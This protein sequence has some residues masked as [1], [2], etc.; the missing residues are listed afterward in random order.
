MASRALD[1]DLRRGAIE[2]W[3]ERRA[4]QAVPEGA[5]TACVHDCCVRTWGTCV[6]FTPYLP[7]Y[8]RLYIAGR[9]S[10]P[11]VT[12]SANCDGEYRFLGVPAPARP[13]SASG[14]GA[15]GEDCD[16]RAYVYTYINGYGEE[17]APSPPSGLLTVRDGDPVLVSGL[18]PP[19]D[20]WGVV[21][22]AVY[23]LAT[24]ARDVE[25]PDYSMLAGWLRVA[26]LAGFPP[27]YQDSVLTRRL[28]HALDTGR[29]RVPPPDL[30]CL[31]HLSGTGTLCGVTANA[32]HFSENFRP[33]SWPAELDNT[34]PFN[35]ANMVTLDATVLLTSDGRAYAVDA[36]NVCEER[37]L[38]PFRDTDAP[39]PDI[40]CGHAG[41]CAATPFGM[42]F[43]SVQGLILLR[44]DATY[45]VLTAPWY[46]QGQWMRM[47][48]E[49]ARLAYWRGL[50]F[51]VTDRESLVIQ[52]D[53]EN[54]DFQAGALATISDRPV[55]MTVT[56][57]GE[58]MMLEGDTV[59]QWDA[60]DSLRPYAWDSAVLESPGDVSWTAVRAGVRGQATFVLE[61]EG[62]TARAERVLDS[63]RPA[64]VP[65]LGRR[66]RWRVGFR[67]TGTVEW[68]ELGTSL[69]SLGPG[70]GG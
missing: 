9:S 13:P 7:D 51:C 60:G 63:P 2:P 8:G 17:S 6:S 45:N 54:R 1:A 26:S 12:G 3:R 18:E 10:R 41:S 61:D 29:V 57:S 36:S 48:P 52:M 23:R 20:G 53:P 24:G 28:G 62:G 67:G 15:A 50:L 31:R 70:E 21:G 32:L 47:R 5:A 55:D 30:R 46:G 11:E 42:A 33:H 14:G 38:K 69:A 44:P 64:R 39:L 66:R 35:V 59:W 4:V 37:K 43:A 27:A 25:D 19:P 58:L 68:A 22:V 49:T 16:A 34:L 65:R 40:G 56:A